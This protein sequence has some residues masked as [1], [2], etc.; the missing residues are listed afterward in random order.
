VLTVT[1]PVTE[2][3]QITVEPSTVPA[4]RP[5]QVQV[6]EVLSDGTVE[7]VLT[8][9]TW[10]SSDT[11]VAQISSTGVIT[12]R[13]PGTVLLTAT[14][15]IDTLTF[16]TSVPITVGAPVVD[17]LR[18][19]PAS[20]TLTAGL[21]VE[22]Q[23]Q[24]VL[25]DGTLQP[26]LGPV[27]W[28][29]S[30]TSVVQVSPTGTVTPLRDGLATLTVT[31]TIEGRTI[32][33]TVLV[34]VGAPVL[35]ALEVRTAPAET[36]LVVGRTHLFQAIVTGRF[37]NGERRDLSSRAQLGWISSNMTV[38][39][40]GSAGLARGISQG[41]ATLTVTAR[42]DTLIGQQTAVVTVVP[43]VVERLLIRATTVTLPAGR[44]QQLRA[45]AVLSDGSTV[46]VTTGALW[47]TTA[48]A[49]VTVEDTPPNRKGVVTAR[50]VGTAGITA[51]F[52]GVVSDTLAFTVTEAEIVRVVVDPPEVA[53]AVGDTVS[54]RL[55]GI[56]SDSSQVALTAGVAWT[57]GDSTIATVGTTG[58]VRGVREGTVQIQGRHTLSGFVN[59][60]N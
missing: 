7:P 46:D 44:T 17:S 48:P 2:A 24:S 30:D 18:V 4:G 19:L 57:A 21:P 56:R 50:T 53:I 3:V 45:E 13:Q 8:P 23:V 12:T 32:S 55:V 51:T 36:T 54:V 43:A 11:N 31:A 10:T 5:V 1:A 38:A 27:T 47:Q 35:L 37:S 59:Q 33:A 58:V 22:A 26:W 60:I 6:E 9:I 49:V 15:L 41:R 39:T 29:V 40:I 20:T 14:T 42:V 25:S 16:S 28:T 34:T 52:G